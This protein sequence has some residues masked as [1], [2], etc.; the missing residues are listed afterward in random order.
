MA[1]RAPV[2]PALALPVAPAPARG[3][4]IE[5]SWA[6]ESARHVGTVVHAWL[7]RYTEPG[8][9]WSAADLPR[10][11]ARIERELAEAGVPAPERAAAATRVRAAL[12]AALADPRGRWLLEATLEAR[13]EWRLTG[14]EGG[15]LIDVSIDRSFVDE[16]GTR[17]IVDYKSGSHQGGDAAGFLDREQARYREQLER[18][19][20]LVAALEPG[21]PIRVGLYFPLMQAWREW[22]PGGQGGTLL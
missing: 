11:G 12:A 5:F 9:R 6:G 13:S 18:Y 20:R 21:R 2:T 1:W 22:A 4:A 3:E 19:A 15:A 16:A 8:G 14:L 7:A 10:A 17:W